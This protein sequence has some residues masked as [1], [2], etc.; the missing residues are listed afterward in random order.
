[1][2]QEDV[3]NVNNTL[4]NVTIKIKTTSMF[5]QNK[6]FIISTLE[7]IWKIVFIV[8]Q[9]TNVFCKMDIFFP[10]F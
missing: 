10:F 7:Q 1:M 3:I 6:I 8:V 9:S 4:Q 2:F 5:F